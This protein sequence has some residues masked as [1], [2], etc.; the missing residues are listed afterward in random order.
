MFSLKNSKEKFLVGYNTDQEF[1]TYNITT[2]E[3]SEKTAE[4]DKEITRILGGI[5]GSIIDEELPKVSGGNVI[6]T[7]TGFHEVE[8]ID[9]EEVSYI[10]KK[11]I[12]YINSISKYSFSLLELGKTKLQIASEGNSISKKYSV[13]FFINEKDTM[14]LKRLTV[15]FSTKQFTTYKGT[16][17]VDNVIIPRDMVLEVEPILPP[18]LNPIVLNNISTKNISYSSRFSKIRDKLD[19]SSAYLSDENYF[20]LT[21]KD[22]EKEKERR[23][24]AEKIR[25]EYRCMG[26]PQSEVIGDKVECL[27]FGGFWDRP[28]ETSQA[29]PFYQKNTN[30][31]NK[32]GGVKK[33]YCEMPSGVKIKGFRNY[34]QSPENY[35]PLCYNCKS[36]LIGQGSLGDCCENQ[37]NDSL[38]YP[39]LKSPDYKFPGDSIDRYNA[40]RE[41]QS[42]GLKYN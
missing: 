23:E 1:E 41:F 3:N 18:A 35:K 10:L 38:T 31:T 36:G 12:A 7:N 20:L 26:I 32:R 9:K 28:A 27:D 21:K 14:Y 39:N 22:I 42:S 34:D 8:F 33:D 13:S 16:V 25:K 17:K 4:I 37:K 5:N 2:D 30:Y 24:V 19:L 15:E 6:K 29:C 40:R 11:F